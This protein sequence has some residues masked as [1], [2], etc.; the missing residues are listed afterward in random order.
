MHVNLM[1]TLEAHRRARRSWAPGRQAARQPTI[2]H[3]AWATCLALDL[4]TLEVL[5]EEST[6]GL[7]NEDIARTNFVFPPFEGAMEGACNVKEGKVARRSHGRSPTV[8]R[9]KLAKE[10][11]DAHARPGVWPHRVVHACNQYMCAHAHDQCSRTTKA[12]ITVVITAI[13]P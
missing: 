10:D 12:V 4:T 5:P 7:T 9:R 1:A 2:K 11:L 6:I 13:S 3:R 8:E